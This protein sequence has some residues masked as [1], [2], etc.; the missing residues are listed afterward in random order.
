LIII[1]GYVC[2]W[3]NHDGSGSEGKRAL[4]SGSTAGIGFAAA[5]ALA[6]EGRDVIIN[7]RNQVRVEQALQ[8]LRAEVPG[9][10]AR[11]FAL[12]LGS[13]AGC[14]ELFRQLP[15]LDILV[16]NWAYSS[17]NLRRHF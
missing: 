1:G 17:P 12:D 8:R 14:E 10:Q 16:N 11:G 6:A 7:G 2:D 3:S 15:D 4:V 13:A 5:S 9:A